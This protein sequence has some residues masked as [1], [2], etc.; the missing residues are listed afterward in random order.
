M[1][2]PGCGVIE[3]LLTAVFLVSEP[4]RNMSSIV[5]RSQEGKTQSICGDCNIA[6]MTEPLTCQQHILT[7]LNHLVLLS[8]VKQEEQENVFRQERT[9]GAA[10]TRAGRVSA[11]CM[12]NNV[13]VEAGRLGRRKKAWQF[14]GLVRLGLLPSF[15]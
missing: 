3:E 1:P 12:G 15:L 10:L 4:V 2:V 9:T 8:F 14:H 13:E 11:V 7:S 5:G 6:A